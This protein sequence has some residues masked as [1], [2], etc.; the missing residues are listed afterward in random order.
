MSKR[1]HQ[2]IYS[3]LA[4][5]P[6]SVPSICKC[7]TRVQEDAINSDKDMSLTS[8]EAIVVIVRTIVIVVMTAV[9]KGNNSSRLASRNAKRTSRNR[10]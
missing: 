1:K 4:E 10:N 9:R 7:N 6:I 2:E 5:L 8:L 3:F